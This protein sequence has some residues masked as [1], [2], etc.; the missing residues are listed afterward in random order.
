M[1]DGEV[2]RYTDRYIDRVHRFVDT[3]IQ[4]IYY[5]ALAYMIMEGKKSPNL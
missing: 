5:K 4:W 1:I 3:H 2:D